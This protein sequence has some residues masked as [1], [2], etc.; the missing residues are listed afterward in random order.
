MMNREE[1]SRMESGHELNTLVAENLP[2]LK[3]THPDYSADIAA[4][5]GLHD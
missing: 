1:I 5:W 2:G 4:A 3:S